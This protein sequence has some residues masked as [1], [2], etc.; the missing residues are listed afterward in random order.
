MKRKKEMERRSKRYSKMNAGTERRKR[1]GDRGRESHQERE[2]Y[3]EIQI[4]AESVGQTEEIDR[5][6]GQREKETGAREK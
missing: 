2:T 4:E 3:N 6:I 1:Q 5:A